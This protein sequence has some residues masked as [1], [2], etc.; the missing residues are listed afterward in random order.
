MA[1]DVNANEQQL[2]EIAEEYYDSMDAD[3]FYFYVWGGEDIHVGIYND[4][5]EAIKEAS[6]RSVENLANVL[7]PTSSD[8]ILDLGAGYGGAARY[9]AQEYGCKVSCL[10]LSEVQNKR[11]RDITAEQGLSNLVEVIHGAFESL[12]YEDESFDH[13]WSQDAFLHSGNKKKIFE[14]AFRILKPGGKLVFTD[15]MQADG[16][17]DQEAS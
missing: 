6:R 14:E 16:L 10:N 15:P 1:N 5:N 2:I 4:E 12:P 9:L 7:K 3:Q 11:N 8:M 17:E 13:A